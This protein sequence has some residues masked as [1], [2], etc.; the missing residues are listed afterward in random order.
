[1]VLTS[2]IVPALVF[3]LTQ[4]T[5]SLPTQVERALDAILKAFESEEAPDREKAKED[6]ADLCKKHGEPLI[7]MLRVRAQTAGPEAR[8]RVKDRLETLARI[9]TARKDLA[10]FD[11]VGMVDPRGKKFVSFN[12]GEWGTVGKEPEFY[13]TYALGWVL[14]ESNDKLTLLGDQMVTHTYARSRKL[15]PKWERLKE[16][17]P[18]EAPLPGEYTELDYALFCKEAAQGKDAPSWDRAYFRGGS[19][20]HKTALFAYWALKCGLDDEG[21]E[22]AKEAGIRTTQVNRAD[23]KPVP[24]A[25]AILSGVVSHLRWKAILDAHRGVGRPELLAAWKLLEKH[26]TDLE[27]A[28]EARELRGHYESLIAE[29]EKWIESSQDQLRAQSPE[30]RAKYWIY[31]FRETAAAQ[32][33]DPGMCSVLGSWWERDDVGVGPAKDLIKLGWAAIPSLID[34]MDDLRPLRSVGWHRSFNHSSWFLLRYADGCAQVFIHLTGATLDMPASSGGSDYPAKDGRA[35]EVKE[36]ARKWW[37]EHGAQGPEKYFL[38]QLESA[39]VESQ[40]FA[41]KKLLELDKAKYVQLMIARIEQKKGKEASAL[42]HLVEPYLDKQHKSIFERFLF[43][44]PECIPV[45]PARLLWEKCGDD[46]GIREVISRLKGTPKE[47]EEMLPFLPDITMSF[48]LLRQIDRDYVGD[49]IRDLLR[50]DLPSMRRLALRQAAEFPYPQVAQAL[51]A[52]LDDKEVWNGN[53][54]TYRLGDAAAKSL[55]Q[56]AGL[57]E[58]WDVSDPLEK[59]DRQIAEV[60]AWWESHKDEVDWAALRG[61]AKEARDKRAADK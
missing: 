52:Q 44:D 58:E 3:L 17:H 28:R 9:A 48:W 12:T 56:S 46:R 50:H 61:K 35:G 54:P 27:G 22:L 1:M 42:F 30:A 36:A 8:A 47:R 16:Q 43:E 45:T 11:L 41:A 5:S 18:K 39:N 7:G 32:D 49:A 55:A 6:L 51:A 29:D 25:A 26:T 31:K 21:L 13:F 24:F 60:K 19:N 38:R 14:D 34:H 53:L 40:G 57:L 10:A 59:R 15:P 2:T 4:D 20:Y 37:N 33:M 23:E